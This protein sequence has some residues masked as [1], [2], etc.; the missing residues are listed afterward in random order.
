MSLFTTSMLVRWYQR[1]M[2]TPSGL[3]RNFSKFHLMSWFRRGS[4]KSLLGFPNSSATGGQAFCKGEPLHHCLAPPKSKLGAF[5]SS[6]LAIAPTFRKVKIFCSLAPF[7]SPFWNSW[8]LGT[9]PFPGRTYLRGTG[10]GCTGVMT[11]LQTPCLWATA[12]SS[13][14]LRSYHLAGTPAEAG[15]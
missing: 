7:T 14:S 15:K 4:Q 9:K 11:G 3:T 1:M 8:K 13:C 5:P 6:P 10:T 2:G 12:S